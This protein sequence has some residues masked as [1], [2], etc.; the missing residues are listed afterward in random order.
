MTWDDARIAQERAICERATAAP[1]LQPRPF[2]LFKPNTPTPTESPEN[3]LAT[4]DSPHDATFAAH[5]RTALPEALDEIE[6]LQGVVNDLAFTDPMQDLAWAGDP[7]GCTFCTYTTKK[8]S[9]GTLSAHDNTCAWRR[10]NEAIG[11]QP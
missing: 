11:R 3:W 5:A 9:P 2:I 8:A 7:F 10:A 1:W 4:F 6:R